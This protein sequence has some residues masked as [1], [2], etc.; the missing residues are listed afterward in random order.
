M[1]EYSPDSD[2]TA[3]SSEPPADPFAAAEPIPSPNQDPFTEPEPAVEAAADE[4]IVDE[5]PAAQPA[6]VAESLD[7]E[8]PIRILCDQIYTFLD[9]VSAEAHGTT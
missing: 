8:T 4:A 5:A 9:R 7:A 1:T 6:E 3:P 2:A